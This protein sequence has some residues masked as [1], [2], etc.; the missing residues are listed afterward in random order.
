MITWTKKFKWL[1]QHR[2]IVLAAPNGSGW[3]ATSEQGLK[4]DFNL[5]TMV[6]HND[7][8]NQITGWLEMRLTEFKLLTVSLN[9]NVLLRYL[10]GCIEGHSRP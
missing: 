8:G 2:Y 9:L 7:A 6:V 4:I 10:H 1:E 5:T 3:T